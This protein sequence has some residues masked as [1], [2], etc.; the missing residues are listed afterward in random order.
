MKVNFVKTHPDAQLPKRNH[1]NMS[2]ATQ[3]MNDELNEQK[4]KL[5]L[6]GQLPS[7]IS[8]DFKRDDNNNIAG[9]CDSGYDIFAVEDTIIRA[10]S[11]TEVPTGIK[12]GYITPGFW[13]RIEGRSGLSFKNNIIP[14]FG[15][16]DN[17][18]A[19]NLGILLYNLSNNDYKV[20]KG[21]KIAQLVIYPV[22][23][24][25]IGW[26][27]EAHETMRGERGIGSSDNKSTLIIP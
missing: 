23:E 27:D 5:Q 19:G 7:G 18:Y 4:I 14:H 22:I 24:A 12:V 25:E 17:S 9:T 11:A 13:F 1:G 10:K 20:H 6:K 15:I 3:L 21:D 26:V 2:I 8:I 16:V